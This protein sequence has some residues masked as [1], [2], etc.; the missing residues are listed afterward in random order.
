[1]R[2]NA[3]VL[4]LLLPWGLGCASP[5]SSDASKRGPETILGTWVSVESEALGQRWKESGDRM[6][7]TFTNDKVTWQFLTDGTWKSYDGAYR[8]D[9]SREP[10]QI[11]LTPPENHKD[12]RPG[13]YKIE[14]DTLTIVLGAAR[15]KDFEEKA[16][17]RLVL[18]R[19]HE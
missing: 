11:D 3:F 13:I 4:V 7:L 19:A 12:F 10:K 9:P 16:P 17:A 8:I 15:P 5:A 6:R 14:G 1:M 18:E 2:A